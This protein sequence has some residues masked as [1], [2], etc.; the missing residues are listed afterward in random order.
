MPIAQLQDEK[1]G[2]VEAGRIRL[3]EKR[4]SQKTK[5]EYPAELPYFALRDAPDLL[6]AFGD[7]PTV[8]PVYL[9]YRT[10]DENF[11]VFM[12]EFRAGGL[13]CQGDGDRITRLVD[14]GNTGAI[15]IRDGVTI[16][17]HEDEELD[18][19]HVRRVVGEIARCPGPDRN[20]YPR[21]ANCRPRGMLFVMV[22]D[23]HSPFEML[24]RR[25][26][27]Y[28]LTTSSTNNIRE[29]TRSLNTIEQISRA[30]GSGETRGMTLI[31][32]LLKRVPGTVSVA[33]D[34]GQRMQTEKW[35]VT[36]E[37]DPIMQNAAARALAAQAR[38]ALGV[39]DPSD[40]P[41]PALPEPDEY[42]EAEWDDVDDALAGRLADLRALR[43]DPPP[44]FA[45]ANGAMEAF[46][47]SAWDERRFYLRVRGRLGLAETDKLKYPASWEAMCDEMDDWLRGEVEEQAA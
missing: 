32:C 15:V 24:D 39:D 16:A 17:E 30:M 31:P 25:L 28:T 45:A 14:P 11:R 3:G 13:Y 27:F 37:Y 20:L 12:E 5:K 23:P 29:I 41:L 9:P 2:F 21:C 42:E 18:G 10:R 26:V 44:S 46:A 33:G 7:Q 43:D 35:F 40:L 36:L 34:N 19:A 47:G 4:I 8:L 22:R 38:G 6:P 1:M